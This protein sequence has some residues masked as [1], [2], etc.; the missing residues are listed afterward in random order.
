M[1]F[2]GVRRCTT[3]NETEQAAI[4]IRLKLFKFNDAN[5]TA[6]TTV[7]TPPYRSFSFNLVDFTDYNHENPQ[8]Q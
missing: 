4:D 8:K 5:Q 6:G 2:V 1:M 3:T 7:G